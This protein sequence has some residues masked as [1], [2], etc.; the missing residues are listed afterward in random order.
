MLSVVERSS[1]PIARNRLRSSLST[2]FAWLIREGL[3]DANPVQ[4]TGKASERRRDRVLLESELVAIWRAL[5]EGDAGDIVRLL[6]LNGQR[7][8]EIARLRW[9][10]VDFDRAMIA[11]P[12]ERT[13]NGLRHELPL[14]PPALDILRR[15]WAN[16]SGKA[17]DAYSLA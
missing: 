3:L 16:A 7:R 4:G 5:S 10:E 9:S 17:N 13:K 8:D 11:L 2:F 14:A 15:R 1:G 12:P 6:I